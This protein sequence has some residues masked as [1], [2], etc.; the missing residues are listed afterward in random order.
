MR[1]NYLLVLGSLLMILGTA[2][3]C[4]SDYTPKLPGL[5]AT[6]V[7]SKSI[8]TPEKA[9]EMLARVEAGKFTAIFVE[10]FVFGR[11]NYDSAL[12]EKS[13]D[14]APNFD[15]L[16]YVVE[17]AHQ[18]DIQ[19]H[20]WLIAGPVGGLEG[21][22]LSRHPDWAMFS[23]DGERANW[24]NYNRPDVRQF[25]SD[26][27]LE[28][29]SKYQVD[30]IH[31]DYT[32]YPSFGWKWGFD[33][34][35][36][37]LFAQETGLDPESLRYADLPAY[38]VFGGN[39]LLGVSTAQ[40]LAEFDNGRPAILLN[41]YGDGQ[42]VLF[43]WEAD[44]R[45]IAASSE[46][47]RCSI[48][49]LRGDGGR[50]YILRSQTNAQKYGWSDFKQTFTWLSDIDHSPVEVS[51]ENV[52]ALEPGSVLVMP[53]VY[54]ISPQVA[55]DLAEL[56]DQGLGVIFIDGPTPSIGDKNIQEITGMTGRGKSFRE[57]GLLLATQP[58]DL[59]PVNNRRSTRLEDYRLV[60]AQWTAFRERGINQLLES[61]YDRL[62]QGSPH[63]LVTITVAANQETLAQNHF[64][65]WQ[66]WLAGQYVDLIIP[67]A[68]VSEAEP[69]APVIASWQ[70]TLDRSSRLMLGVSVYDH[71]RSQASKTSARLLAEIKEVYASN[72]NGVILF[73]LEGISDDG[74]LRLANGPFSTPVP[75]D[76]Q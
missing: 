44:E 75:L 7:Q 16:A 48:K 9:D 43:N 63:V 56:V 46:I 53:S 45:Q 51:E 20:A 66:A 68:Y 59:I 18:R 39:P 27:A 70:P 57:T 29:A 33:P 3:Q 47:L 60:N 26:V 76:S 15:P 55:A 49:Y 35:S 41:K 32:R 62:K 31:F 6:W 10:S 69:L 17:Q 1:L 61:V 74:L 28:I 50:V 64:L 25:I 30:G 21:P 38:G 52:S 58:N 42:V 11:A 54:L 40:V 5:R 8:K 34:Y 72:S 22:I 24:L 19:V 73:D 71:R 12:L 13:T 4:S 37:Q 36:R 67:R 23:V 65:D 14:L 2:S